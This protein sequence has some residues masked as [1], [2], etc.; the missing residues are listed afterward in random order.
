M[1]AVWRVV[2]VLAVVAP[3][4]TGGFYLGLYRPGAPT[5]PDAGGSLEFRPE[6]ASPGQRPPSQPLAETLSGLRGGKAVSEVTFESTGLTLEEAQAEYDRRSAK[7]GWS[8]DARL[9]ETMGKDSRDAPL[10]VYV[11]RGELRIVIVGRPGG[12]PPERPVTIYTGRLS[13]P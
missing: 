8:Y 5:A 13:P 2:R 11:R 1:S 4:V 9:T 7:D 3:I 10:R 12:E 6:P